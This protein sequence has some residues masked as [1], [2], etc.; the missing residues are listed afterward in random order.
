[1]RGVRVPIAKLAA[2]EVLGSAA[3]ADRRATCCGSDAGVTG[4]ADA[5]GN[6]RCWHPGPDGNRKNRAE[7]PE[8]VY[9]LRTRV[10][11]PDAG[12]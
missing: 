10:R 7:N 12:L 6:P 5:A 11:N 9:L 2:V 8:R 1:V 4:S 3:V